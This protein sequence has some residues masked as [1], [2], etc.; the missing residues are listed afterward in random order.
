LIESGNSITTKS[1]LN[2]KS[3]KKSDDNLKPRGVNNITRMIGSPSYLIDR[4]FRMEF[5]LV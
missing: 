4:T 1:R 2:E 5:A 3:L